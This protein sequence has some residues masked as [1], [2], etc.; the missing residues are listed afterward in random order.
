MM[1][2][3]TNLDCKSFSISE[4]L[5]VLLNDCGFELEVEHSKMIFL[6]DSDTLADDDAS[7]Y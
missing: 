3:Q 5:V 2:H 6:N 4:D 7:P 1:Y